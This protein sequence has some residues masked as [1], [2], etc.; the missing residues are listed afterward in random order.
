MSTLTLGAAIKGSPIARLDKSDKVLTFVNANVP[1]LLDEIDVTGE[2]FRIGED[3]TGGVRVD[4]FMRFNH[5]A[6]AE[7]TGG[8]HWYV[9]WSPESE[10]GW[11]EVV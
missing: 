6:A 4:T 1:I 10:D 5:T 3:R 9:V 8:I 2:G 11:L 7:A